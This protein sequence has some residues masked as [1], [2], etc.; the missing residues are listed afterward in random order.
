MEIELQK[1][2]DVVNRLFD[3]IIVTRDIGKVE[4]DADFYWDIPEEKR[5]SATQ[6]QPDDLGVGDL[7]DDWEFVSSLLKKGSNPVAYQLTE[8]APLL[9]RIGEVLGRQLADKGG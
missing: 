5:Y 8:V 9:R 6:P 2:R 1:L 4:L 3:H 7:E